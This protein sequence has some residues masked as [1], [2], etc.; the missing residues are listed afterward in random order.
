[1]QLECLVISYKW[2]QTS[3]LARAPL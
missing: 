2:C 3:I 1:M